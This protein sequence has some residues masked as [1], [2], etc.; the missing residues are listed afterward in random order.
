MSKDNPVGLS[1]FAL[2]GPLEKNVL[3]A[4]PSTD[5]RGRPQIKRRKGKGNEKDTVQLIGRPGLGQLAGRGLC[6]SGH[7]NADAKAHADGASAD[8]NFTT[9]HGDSRTDQR[10]GGT[11]GH[12]ENLG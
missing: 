5:Q 7:T 4:S 3:A 11:C 12:L 9:A 6:P 8:C 1:I 10:G 2:K